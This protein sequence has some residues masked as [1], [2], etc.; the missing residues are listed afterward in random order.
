MS[1]HR[2]I[3][4][5]VAQLR[6]TT[7]ASLGGV[8]VEALDAEGRAPDLLAFAVADGAGK[9]TMTFDT[10]DLEQILGDRKPAI[11]FKLFQ[12]V[13]EVTRL[14][15]TNYVLWKPTT[16][17]STVRIQL[18]QGSGR[19]ISMSPT[20]SVVRGTVR[21]AAGSAKANVIVRAFDKGLP[22]TVP[23]SETQLGTD[24]VADDNGEYAI[25][26]PRGFGS[27]AWLPAP[28]I[29]VRAYDDDTV[30]AESA[31]VYNARPTIN[32]DLIEGESVFVGPSEHA[33]VTAKTAPIIPSGFQW[34]SA[35]AAQRVHISAA[36]EAPPARVNALAAAESLSGTTP[37]V[38]SALFYGLVRHGLPSDESQLLLTGQAGLREA[39]GTARDKN[40]IAKAT[41]DADITA[42]LGALRTKIIDNTFPGTETPVGGVLRTVL[43]EPDARSFLDAYLS[44]EAPLDEF[45]GSSAVASSYPVSDVQ[46]ALQAGL[47][48]RFHKPLV[49]ELQ[50]RRTGNGNLQTLR[51]FA[52]YA[53]QDWHDVL[54][55]NSGTVGH[56]SDMNGDTTA[57]RTANYASFLR[58]TMET[59]FPTASIAGD[60]SRATDSASQNLTASFFPNHKEFE[61]GKHRVDEYFAASSV[62]GVTD[63]GR[64]RLKHM[65]RLFRLTPH[66]AEMELLLSDG[67]HSSRE[68]LRIG[69]EA[70]VAKYGATDKL[71]SA[72]IAEEIWANARRT[73]AH[74]LALHAKYSATMNRRSAAALPDLTTR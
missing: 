69:H 56:P 13:G 6:G 33:D 9:F 23:V 16:D 57:E 10:V 22:D 36:S 70:F 66:H 1:T 43:S 3:G 28:N 72:A 34:A 60:V 4:Q 17:E 21:T 63:E 19:S 61:L 35:T 65:E 15:N 73:A 52:S 40:T 7:S 12:R 49:A 46:F 51:D 53:E 14:L 64:A 54:T 58:R 25:S 8:R 5:I 50:A 42:A 24:A 2:L 48:S 39:L 11:T 74:A 26:Y 27:T 31:A 68:V 41:S 67:L 20:D 55:Q 30:I 18:V 29:L 62:S 47:L 38:S 45:W 44:H 32:V 37:S 59:L 71:G